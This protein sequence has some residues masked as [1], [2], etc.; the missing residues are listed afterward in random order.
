MEILNFK[1][2]V[3]NPR[4]HDF[5]DNLGAKPGYYL[6]KVEEVHGSQGDK[7]APVHVIRYSLMHVIG[8]TTGLS[9]D[10]GELFLNTLHVTVIGYR[11]L[12]IDDEIK[13][14]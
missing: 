4:S 10:C 8:C 2:C 12:G 14:I 11:E 1:P 6:L 9:A 5:L 7:L 3:L 13:L